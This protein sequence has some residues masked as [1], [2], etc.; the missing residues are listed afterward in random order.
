M[1]LRRNSAAR[2]PL[3]AAHRQGHCDIGVR[4]GRIAVLAAAIVCC[5]PANAGTVW[6]VDASAS[7]GNTGQTWDDAFVDLLH[8]LAEWGN[9]GGPEDINGDGVVNVLD[10]LQLLSEWGPCG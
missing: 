1:S 3:P 9:P 6:F 7:G 5:N 2:K 4:I 8:V 10:L